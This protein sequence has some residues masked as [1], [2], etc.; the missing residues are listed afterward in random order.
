MPE[1]GTFDLVLCVGLLYHLEN[2]F[3][4]VRNLFALTGKLLA[5]ESMCAPGDH[6]TMELLD[7]FHEEDQGLKHV[8]FY[9]TESCV[10]KMLYQAGFPFVYEFKQPPN[11]PAFRATRSR[12][13][14]RTMLVASRQG[15]SAGGL[16]EILELKRPWDIW[17]KAGLL[18]GMRAKLGKVAQAISDSIKTTALE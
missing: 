16:A 13:R 17:S 9:P 3:L 5:I 4:A 6:P 14:E 11:H 18:G 12:H 7:E 15:L 8:A 2:P 10:V 1:I